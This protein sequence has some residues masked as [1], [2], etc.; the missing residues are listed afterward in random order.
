VQTKTFSQGDV[1]FREE[2][3]SSEAY[4]ILSG[5]VEISIATHDGARTLA[6]LTAG[7]FFGEMSLIDDK[8]RSATATALTDCEVEVI[9]EQNFEERV[10][11]DPGNLHVYLRTLF[12]RLRATDALLQWHLN[13]AAAPGQPKSSIDAAL[14]GAGA[15]K[16]RPATPPAAEGLPRLRLNSTSIGEVQTDVTVT[17]IPFRIGR[18]TEGGHGLMPLAHN[19]LSIPDR[20]PYHVSRNHCVIEDGD[21][22]LQV[23]DLGSRRG[24]IVNGAK[25]GID[26]ESFVAPLK[27][28]DNIF[29]LGDAH[30]PHHFRLIV[31]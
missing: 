2:D 25:L 7:D 27:P 18:A 11:G 14:H 5:H 16:Q 8:P 23:R 29:T 13:R 31:L 17:K 19:D 30:G 21:H 12:D 3:E 24:T 4:R 20:L 15:H 1:I 28:G 9:H 10:L 6:Q 22:G 26:H